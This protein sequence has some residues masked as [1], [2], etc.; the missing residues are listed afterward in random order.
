M[1]QLLKKNPSSFI[2]LP[3]VSTFR[4]QLRNISFTNQMQSINPIPL[5]NPIL[6]P[7]NLFSLHYKLLNEVLL[8]YHC[9]FSFL[10]LKHP[11]QKQGK[12]HHPH[13]SAAQHLPDHHTAQDKI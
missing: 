2:I 10:G 7:A 6:L 4:F 5:H 1:K 12:S 9:K 8:S 3:H 13:V 11:T